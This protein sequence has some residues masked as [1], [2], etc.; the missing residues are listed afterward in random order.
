MFLNGYINLEYKCNIC[1][2]KGFLRNGNKCNCLKQEIIN[3]LIRCPIYQ[4]SLTKK[5]FDNFDL[6]LFSTEKG[7]YNI[8]PIENME[9]KYYLYVTILLKILLKIME[10]TYYFMVI[11]V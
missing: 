2:D 7:E 11:Q 4:E 6:S 10:K 5:T 9:L 8:S 3:E 1:K